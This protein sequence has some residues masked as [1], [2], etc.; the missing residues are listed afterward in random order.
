MCRPRPHH[1]IFST[2]I[3]R[4]RKRSYIQT[5][6]WRKIHCIAMC[7]LSRA[8]LS[9]PRLVALV[10]PLH[11]LRAV[12]FQW[13]IHWGTVP[14]SLGFHFGLGFLKASS[15]LACVL[16]LCPSLFVFSF[17][18]CVLPSLH[19]LSLLFWV[20][21]LL[22]FL[23]SLVFILSYACISGNSSERHKR[24]RTHTHTLKRT[25]T[26]ASEDDERQ[27][28]KTRTTSIEGRM[29]DMRII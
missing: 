8:S 22:S 10:A 15:S 19:S 14:S 6:M 12:Y 2:L 1:T 24:M 20:Y 7:H 9:A 21:R 23:Y 26:H 5:P 4:Q 11:S 27:R 18:W 17:I 3:N 28:A 25:L 16:F 13:N 29:K